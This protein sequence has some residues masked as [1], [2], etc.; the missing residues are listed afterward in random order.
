LR[1]L[2]GCIPAWAVPCRKRRHQ[3]GAGYFHIQGQSKA[4][5]REFSPPS[6][7]VTIPGDLSAESL[8][9]SSM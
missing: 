7:Q 9:E 3:D 2:T 8:R 5:Q 1:W 4:I 6:N